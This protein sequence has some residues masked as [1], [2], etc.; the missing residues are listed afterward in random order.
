MT[1]LEITKVPNKGDKNSNVKV[2]QQRLIDLGYSVGA[3]DGVYGSQTLKAISNLQKKNGLNGSGIIGPN[4]LS[5]LGITLKTEVVGDYKFLTT[6]VKGKQ[7]RR[8][9]PNLR[10]RLEQT[11]F[12]NGIPNSFLNKDPQ[13]MVIDVS[14]AFESLS[15]REQGGNN[16]G[17]DVGA[18]QSIIGSVT[19]NGN[20]DAWCMSAAQCIIAFIEDYLQIES[21]VPASESCM[22]T[23]T[24]AR[25]IQGLVTNSCEK[26]TFFIW[27]NGTSW[28]GHTGSVIAVLSE[29]KMKTAE[30]NTGDGN[31]RDGDGFYFRERYI[32]KNG[33]MIGRGFIRV[34]PYNKIPS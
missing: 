9:H 11:V 32:L 17:K 34:Y 29:N 15:I 31:I 23:I 3:V 26:G 30:G 19:E 16:K 14:K 10:M 22:S 24:D 28:Q 8:L 21:P 20:G 27:Q 25:K 6:D 13:E 33:K 2:I 5:L 7:A 12:K 4:T 1:K 18:I